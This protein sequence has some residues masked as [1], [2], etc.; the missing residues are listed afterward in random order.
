MFAV[1]DSNSN[2]AF[3]TGIEIFFYEEDMTGYD[4]MGGRGPIMSLGECQMA[5]E[6][7]RAE[8]AEFRDKYIRAVAALDNKRKQAER[9]TNM[10]LTERV[11]GY[12][13]RMIEVADNLERALVHVG[14]GDPL[15]PGVRATLQQ[16]QSA[17]RQE[18]V[19]PLAVEPGAPFDPQIHE[20]ISGYAAD[21]PRD[22][23]VEITQT[24][25]TLDG[26]VLRPARVVVAHPPRA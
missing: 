21:V 3:Q 2:N 5:L 18:G 26:Q 22:T 13:A 15:Y 12:S 23:V 19:E 6:A 17:L 4:R 24:G 14:E 7:S 16:L 25:Y 20:A 9:D 11:R 1:Y 10:K 8:V